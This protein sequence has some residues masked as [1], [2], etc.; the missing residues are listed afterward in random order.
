MFQ[1]GDLIVYGNMGVCRVEAVETPAGLPGAGEKKLYY[2][3]D[4]VYETGTVYIPVDAKVFMRPILTHAQAEALIGRIPEIE[5]NPCGGKDQQMLAEHY[6][7]LMRTHDCD[8]LVQLIKTIYGKNRERTAQGKKPARTEAEYMKRAEELLHGEL[9]AAERLDGVWHERRER[10]RAVDGPRFRCPQAHGDE[11]VG[12]RCEVFAA[13]CSCVACV[14][15][16]AQGAVEAQF[17]PVFRCRAAVVVGYGQRSQRLV[18]LRVVPLYVELQ[19]VGRPVVFVEE[20]LAY[21]GN[22][23]RGP[24]VFVAVDGFACP[25]GDVVKEYG[26]AVG[27][28]VYQRPHLAVANG[29]GLFEVACRGVIPKQQWRLLCGCLRCG[30]DCHCGSRY[31]VFGCHFSRL[32]L[33]GY[34]RA[35]VPL[36]LRGVAVFKRRAG[37]AVIAWLRHGW[38]SGSS[39]LVS[40]WCAYASMLA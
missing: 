38:F 32:M 14:V 9:A 30:Q 16:L 39:V 35:A 15:V 27:T 7:S 20:R 12:V 34:C 13:E 24:G 26:V 33:S 5:E 36:A 6:R 31:Q 25:Q 4:P 2:K 19:R 18:V 17:P 21:L 11:P 23:P 8:D 3:L 1:K 22:P 10:D 40:V 29:Q 28:A 37:E